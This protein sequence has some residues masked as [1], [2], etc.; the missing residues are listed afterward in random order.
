M[1]LLTNQLYSNRTCKCGKILNRH[2]LTHNV[3]DPYGAEETEEIKRR[4]LIDPNADIS[5][6]PKRQCKI[7]QEL[8]LHC[9]DCGQVF[10]QIRVHNINQSESVSTQSLDRL[11]LVKDKILKDETNGD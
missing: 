5:D 11:T 9:T 6:I 4:R 2:L 7:E 3:T 10:K 8:G 1:G